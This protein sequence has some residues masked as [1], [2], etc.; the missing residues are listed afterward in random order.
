VTVLTFLPRAGKLIRAFVSPGSGKRICWIALV[1]WL[2][3]FLLT[4]KLLCGFSL[5]KPGMQFVEFHPWIAPPYVCYHVGV[6][7]LRVLL[8]LLTGFLTPLSILASWT[9]ITSR[10][11]EFH[12]VLPAV[13]TGMD[14]EGG[15]G[16]RVRRVVVGAT[17]GG[18]LTADDVR[19]LLAPFGLSL[20]DRELDNVLVYLDLLLRW[21]EGI[22]L[23]AV[24]RPED[25]IRRHFGESLFLSRWVEVRG[26]L[27]DVGSGAGFPGL[28]LKLV[29]NDLAAVLLEPVA[30]KRSFLK[31]VARCCSLKGVEVRSERLD[32]FGRPGGAAQFDLVTARAVGDLPELIP[33]ATGCLAPRGRLCIWIGRGQCSAVVHE[34]GPLVWREP[35]PIPLSESRVLLIGERSASDV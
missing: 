28:A 25:C 4:I 18:M 14:G 1:I 12:L 9:G 17:I 33:V 23:T 16:V 15:L 11:R 21:N 31:E 2:I 20:G 29:A 34:S 24:R 8:I 3:E 10:V 35:I 7:G 30:K 13:E 26:K 6:D 32:Q 19:L 5:H 22:N 27:L